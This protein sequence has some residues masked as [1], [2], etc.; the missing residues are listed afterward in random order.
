M[1]DEVLDLRRLG[2]GTVPLQALLFLSTG[3]GVAAGLL[4]LAL[5]STIAVAFVPGGFI[6]SLGAIVT[7]AAYAAQ[8]VA[9]GI[10][11]VILIPLGATL[12]AHLKLRDTARFI[13]EKSGAK[14]LPDSNRAGSAVAAM[15]RKAGLPGPPRYGVLENEINAL[16]LGA[17]REE[18][19]VLVGRPLG[20]ILQPAE[21]MAI[22]GH[23]LGHI[24]MDDSKRK[25][26]AM[27]HQEF[28]FRF[29]VNAGLQR[30]ARSVFGLIGELALAAHSR[31]REF[32]ADAVG[33][34]VTS[35]ADMMAALAKLDA[36]DHPPT[37]QLE[38]DYAPLMLRAG[39]SSL[40]ASHP[41]MAER[42]QA[43]EAETY[44]RR[45]PVRQVEAR[46]DEP[47]EMPAAVYDGI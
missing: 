34:Y 28:L 18:A 17:S 32:W 27:G 2:T 44:L 1:S 31:E 4:L 30:W 43:L 10:A 9:V 12:A 23:E 41:S 24:A 37:T 15:A 42:I 39:R 14:V 29:L 33:A 21:I 35:K 3:I 13:V 40:F 19:L 45:L 46:V 22:I 25:L 5:A 47:A 7:T 20:Q 36:V 8:L 38:R 16:A 26:M 11:A 6:A